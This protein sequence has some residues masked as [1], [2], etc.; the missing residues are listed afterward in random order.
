[1]RVS[2]GCIPISPCANLSIARDGAYRVSSDSGVLPSAAD[3]LS[4]VEAWAQALVDENPVVTNVE[5]DPTCDRWFIRVRGDEKLVTTLWLTVREETI[6]FET[7]FMPAPEEN[8]AACYEYLLRA[9]S[10]FYGLRFSIGVEDAVYLTGQMPF[11][12]FGSGRGDDELDR[13]LGATYAYS[14]EC[15]RTAM[16]IGFTS[17]FAPK[18]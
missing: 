16:R 5:K 14:E 7:Y 10:R 15:F 17:S 13:M 12:A 4:L 1:M 3:V 9:C 6:S 2:D 8:V 18:T 11:S